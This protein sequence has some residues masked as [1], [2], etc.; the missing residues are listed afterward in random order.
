MPTTAGTGSEVTATAFVT[1]YPA[2]R[3]RIIKDLVLIP[4][5][6]VLD[7]T[8]LSGLSARM[9]AYTGMD[10]LTHAVEAY[11]NRYTS[12]QVREY[13]LR[14]VQSIFKHLKASYDDGRN[15]DHRQAMLSAS[16]WAGIAVANAFPGYT[17]ALG[18]AVG[19][20]YRVQ[21]G[22]A[23]AVLLPVV[24]EEYGSAAEKRLSQLGRAIGVQ[25]T[26][27]GEI[28]RGFIARIRT[29]EESVGIPSTISEIREE[30]VPALAACAEEEGNPDYPVP[31]IWNYS[32]FQKVLRCVMGS[33]SQGADIEGSLDVVE[34]G[35]STAGAGNASGANA[36][37]GA[38]NGAEASALGEDAAPSQVRIAK[39]GPLLDD[40]GRLA[41]L[42]YA[43]SLMLDY[44]RKRIKASPLR[45]KEWDYYLV[46][47]DEFAVALTIGDMGYAAL[48][49]ASLLDF[50]QGTFTTQSTMDLLPLGKLGLPHTSTCG[51]TSYEDKRA[52]MAFEV[53]DGM[54]RLAVT[55]DDF[56]DGQTLRAEFVLD[57]EP[58]DSMVI[59]TPWA[60]DG[61]AFYYNQKIIG[62]RAIGTVELGDLRH[63]FADESSF[64]LL[65]W[66]RGVWTHDNTWYWSA[67]QGRQ[68]EHLVG[69]NLGYGFGDTSAASENMLFVDGVAHKLG[70]VD[71]GIP[72]R[73]ATARSRNRSIGER[74]D[75]MSPWH[76]TDDE[77]RVDLVFA[78]QIDRCDYMDFKVVASDQH[79]AF[80]LFS[81]TFVLDD[82]SKLAIEGLRGFAEA[83]HNVY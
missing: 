51:V 55:F 80:G 40:E 38:A 59:A 18:H 74:Y 36:Q 76:I 33:N 66:G 20:R 23:S 67:A 47:D 37:D 24:L 27:D 17:S 53:A 56:L 14:A 78:P 65:D 12:P 45:I 70:R 39:P 83:V 19:G 15:L 77:G 81:G 46:N 58:R 4:N 11:T 8:L 54:R 3:K 50:T 2:R 42:G 41:Q 35:A 5:I 1:D 60:E 6:A 62:M 63:D 30:D 64:G 71:F 79:Q 69:F 32:T 44:D 48:V 22:F 26:T 68:N 7:S 10:A 13:A 73:S 82:G 49:S 75:L 9:T 34:V 31:V 57:Q 29:L 21:H 43:T 16:Y 28:A 52:S 25:G 61:T 72:E